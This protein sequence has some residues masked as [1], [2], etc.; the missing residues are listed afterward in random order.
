MPNQEY[1]SPHLHPKLLP[2]RGI[3]VCL[4]GLLKDAASDSPRSLSDSICITGLLEII[5]AGYRPE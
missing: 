2:L 3:I 5:Q 1:I 4:R